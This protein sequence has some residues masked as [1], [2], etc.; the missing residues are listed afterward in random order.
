MT[1]GV[2][3]VRVTPTDSRLDLSYN[4]SPS[5]RSTSGIFRDAVL[6][7]FMPWFSGDDFA[8]GDHP[9]VLGQGATARILMTPIIASSIRRATARPAVKCVYGHWI[10]SGELRVQ[11]RQ[12]TVAKSGDLILYENDAPVTLT[13]SPDNPCDNLAFIMQKSELAGMPGS[14]T[15]LSPCLLA[16][17]KLF[18][19]LAGCLSMMAR[20]LTT[21]D[22][23]DL[24]GLFR[25]CATLLPLAVACQQKAGESPTAAN[26]M[27]REVRN[28]VDHNLSNP[29]LS[30]RRTAAHFGISVRYIHKLFAMSGTTF[31]AHVQ[32]QRLEHVKW[33]LL[34]NR[35]GRTQIAAVAFRWGFGDLSTFNRAFRKH[36]GCTPSQLAVHSAAPHWTSPH[37]KRAP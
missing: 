1:I 24:A 7:G 13:V 34:A 22:K 35:D 6:K 26:A 36:F 9:V 33:D 2:E 14:T 20:S 23:D 19:P 21:I 12:T 5:I 18:G 16:A 28:F 10:I 31:G 30:P 11:A 8:G 3:G 37:C 32:V 15:S 17:D 4:H 29:D 27:F 25:A